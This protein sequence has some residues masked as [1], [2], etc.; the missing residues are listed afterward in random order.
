MP[1]PTLAS[2]FLLFAVAAST[3]PAPTY[4]VR[5]FRPS[6]V[7]ETFDCDVSAEQHVHHVRH[8]AGRAPAEADF[9]WTVHLAGR[10]TV[11]AVDAKG[12]PTTLD[13]RVSELVTTLT[14]TASPLLPAGAVVRVTEPPGGPRFARLDGPLPP[15][16]ERALALVL[17]AYPAGVPTPDDLYPPGRPRAV[18]ESWP[19]DPTADAALRRAVGGP[20]PAHLAGHATLLA[21][22]DVAGVPCLRVKHVSDVDG[23]V[24]ATR[25]AGVASAHRNELSVSTAALPLDPAEPVVDL[26]SQVTADYDVHG[27]VPDGGP[28]FDEQTHVV[29][30]TH[31]TRT[32]V[33]P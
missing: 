21:R 33:R 19:L 20:P 17:T 30:D 11:R 14:G 15:G 12:S 5:Q 16:G 28:P 32:A 13:C 2:P 23:P 6:H 8:V 18:G 24:P 4:P 1:R 31:A 7:G 3:A 26:V 25:P 9:A 29:T 10:C 27:S 22:A